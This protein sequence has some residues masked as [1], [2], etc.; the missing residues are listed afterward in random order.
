M[1]G[2][3]APGGD[4]LAA[5]VVAGAAGDA[6]VSRPSHEERARTELARLKDAVD[7]YR[8]TFGSMPAS[9]DDLVAPPD[10]SEPLL[11]KAPIDPWGIPYRLR[12]RDGGDYVIESAG[13]DGLFEP[14]DNLHAP[15]RP[16]GGTR[17]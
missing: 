4:P 1:S 6:C 17:R 15:G 13:P 7:M 14:D 2:G 16:A 9:L 8:I 10:G 11:E 3:A 12:M 5:L